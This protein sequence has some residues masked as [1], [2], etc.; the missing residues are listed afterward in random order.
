MGRRSRPAAM[1]A[2]CLLAWAATGMGA[3]KQ[4]LPLPRMVVAKA[5]KP[6]TI[7]GTMAP[8]EW[9][10]AAACSAFTVAFHG[11]LA[12]NQ[13]VA[14]ITYDDAHLY[15]CLKNGRGPH[16]TLLSKRARENDDMKIVFD[17]SNEIWITPPGSPQATYQTLFN[18]YPGVFDVQH[19]PSVG[20]TAMAWQGGW[21]IA[22]SE[23]RDH[24]IVEAKAPLKSFGVE[25]IEAGAVWRG[26]FTTDVLGKG[27]GF[28]AWAPGGGFAEINR[29]G[30]LHFRDAASPIFQLLD[31]ESIFTGKP[32]LRAAVATAPVTAQRTVHVAARFGPSPE[33]QDGDLVVKSRVSLEGG[34]REELTLTAD[35]TTLD[36]PTKKVVVQNKPRVEKQFPHG[37]CELTAKTADGLVLYHQ[38]FP[39]TIDGIVR[40]PPAKIRKSPYDTAFGLQAF[41]APLSKKLLVKI[42]RYYMSAKAVR[43]WA[44]LI[45]PRTGNDLAKRPI[46]PFRNDYSQFAVDLSKLKV[47]TQTKADWEKAQPVIEANKKREKQGKPPKPVPGSQPVQYQLEVELDDRSPRAGPIAQMS[48]PV[49]LMGYQFE[50]LP[51]TIGISEKVIPPWTPLK[52]EDGTVSMWNK[53]YRLNG[54]GLAEAIVNDGHRQL[55]GPM[56]LVA[57][58]N[59]RTRDLAEDAT[60]D[61]GRLTEAAAEQSGMASISDLDVK[62]TTRVEFDGCVVNTMRLEPRRPVF[63]NSLSLVV[64][65]PKPEAPCFVTTAGGWS[66]YHGW[67]P[68]RWTSKETSSGSR[69]GNFVPYVFLTDSDRGFCWFADNDEGW[70]L[71]PD[72]P[73][74]ELTADG[75]TV[76]LRI[77]FVNKAVKLERPTA[78]TY[79][80]MVTPQKPQP[81]G[82][83]ATHITHHKPYPKATAVFYGMDQIDWAVLWPYYS[84][85]YPWDYEKSKKAFDRAREKGVVLCAGNI[86]HAIARYRDGKGRWFKELA[87]D[88]G[89]RP[90]DTSNGNVTR[91]RGTND[92]QLWHFDQ[93]VK[94]SGM[95]GIY[96][97]E[98]YLSEEWN[99]LKGN[100]YLLPDERVQPGYSYLGLREYDKRLRYMFAANGLEPPNL[101]LHTTSGH[102]VYAWMP[103]VAMEGENVNPTSMENDYQSC[104][105]ASRLRAIGMGRNLGAAA[106]IM[107]QADRHWKPEIG[108]FMC[109]QFVGWVLAHDCLPESNHFWPVLA[110][111]LEMWDPAIRFL[112]YW[113][114]RPALDCP[115]EDMVV[116]AHVRPRHAVLWV[117]NTAREARD[118]TVRVEL[119]KLG[120]DASKTVAFDAETGTRHALD[121]PLLAR[122]HRL[123]VRVP[124]RMWRAIRLMHPTRLRGKQTL[125]ASFDGEEVAAD[126]ALGHRYARGKS[127]DPATTVPGG[128]TGRAASLDQGLSFDARHHVTRASGR[129]AFHLRHRGAKAPSGTLLAIDR[130]LTL[131]LGHGKLRLA[132]ARRKT[133][134]EADLALQ[135]NQWHAVVIA[136]KGRAVRVTVDGE[137]VLSATLDGPVP[138]RPMG[139]GFDIQSHRT[140]VKPSRITLGPLDG[141]LLDDLTMAT[142]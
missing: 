39:F 78:L 100:A 77:H 47:P 6:P 38:V 119:D 22:S 107:C 125:V 64:S 42:D 58:V 25:A 133:R 63:L 35:L 69:V 86:A 127:P 2:I 68:Q 105:P 131:R 138:V 54:L 37:V 140:R 118:A 82:W 48:I 142:P 62:V 111:E 9:D 11:H 51:N 72:K 19:I 49:E 60:I 27:G 17:H 120:F 26:L 130:D 135:P 136:W 117:V 109:E 84:S 95:H 56:K 91:C 23:S 114:D 112:P 29:H 15:V 139:R 57:V 66:A 90:G 40:K 123:T 98:N 115:T 1:V 12:K 94:R 53:T 96:F 33:P 87:A 20:Y 70:I 13:S 4:K 7:D 80:W 101:W 92:F 18:A 28:R 16:D 73:T 61:P 55:R 31:V 32:T 128:K 3:D 113:K 50:W 45:D 85:P 44:R 30:W 5:A 129:I 103:D 21:D 116:S 121:R 10:R 65:M 89:A 124:S 67:T 43:G 104:L 134:A 99:Y 102:P 79:G 14:W 41:H 75:D 71:D 108:R 97:D 74:Q 24:W 88:W 110:A 126:E 106:L 36:L 137:E 93:W 34:G 52:W 132:A 76:T 122:A 8:G 46:A 59:A 141:A 81:P 83:R